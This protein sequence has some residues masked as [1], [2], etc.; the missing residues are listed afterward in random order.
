[1]SLTA[2]KAKR[3]LLGVTGGIAAYKA[4]ELAR[5]LVRA[6][7]E[8]RVVMTR[9]ATE[10]V[11]PLT[12]QA[13][14]GH[15]VHT[16]LLSAEAENAMGHI[17]LAR[18]ADVVLV[19]PASADFL[20]RLNAGRADDLLAA[21]CLATTATIAV[22]PAM[23]QAMWANPATERNLF[24]LR[25]LGIKLFG[26]ATGDQACG[27]T[28]PGRMLEPAEIAERTAALFESEALAGKTVVITAG[29][30]W[31]AID[32]VRGLSNKSSGKMG[33]A[34]AEAA[35]E[36]G[37][38][39]ILVSGP[40]SLA[41]PERAELVNVTSAGEMHAAAMDHIAD[42]D[43]FIGVAAVADYRPAEVKASKIKKDA[44][45][46]SIEL[47]RNPDIL[48]SVADYKHEQRPD[49]LVCGFAAETDEVIE[50]AREKLTRK[51][52][53]MICAN[54]V[55]QNKVF[56]TSENHITIIEAERETDLGS[57]PKARLARALID[58]IS[59]TIKT[60]THA[61]NTTQDPRRT[62]G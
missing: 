4:A 29:P 42:A 39:V 30:T 56:G 28:G 36:A 44:E 60:K 1:M 43:I 54:E 35:I 52:A 53:D 55:G 18:W 57:A 59:Q 61:Q 41:A 19:A 12:F 14:T 31:E 49:L 25:Q 48:K 11:A 26:P 21:V 6:D 5:V 45:T 13:L 27:E 22:A 47:V 17:E 34:I 23:N 46:L 20:A 2:L 37:A 8:V 16:D 50:H 9:G 40:V 58:H 3:I 24:G 62:S 7:A 32:P 51:R 33:Y 15:M 10:F 38:K